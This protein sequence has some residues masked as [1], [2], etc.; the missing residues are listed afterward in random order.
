[1]SLSAARASLPGFRRLFTCLLFTGAMLPSLVSAGALSA[2][3][4]DSFGKYPG[5]SCSGGI[6]GNHDYQRHDGVECDAVGTLDIQCRSI[7]Q[8]GTGLAAHPVGSFPACNNNSFYSTYVTVSAAAAISNITLSM[9]QLCADTASGHQCWN[10]A[11]SATESVVS[12]RYVYTSSLTLTGAETNDDDDSDGVGNSTDN[13]PTI[14]NTTQTDTDSDSIGDACDSDNDNDGIADASDACPFQGDQGYGIDAN[15][16]PNLPPPADEDGDGVEDSIDNCV[17]ISNVDQLNADGDAQGDACDALP[18]NPDVLLEKTGIAKNEQLGSSIAMADMNNDGVVDLLVG[19]PMANKKAG[20]I[21]IISGKNNAALRAITGSAANQQLGAAIAVVP[22][23]NN[24]GV[25]DI[26]VGDPLADVAKLTPNGFSKLKDAGR[27]LLY[28]G[29][30]GRMLRILA[31]GDAAGDHFGVAVAAG[32]VNSDNKVDLIVGAPMNDASVKDAGQVTLFNGISNKLLYTRNGTQTGEHFGAALA[33]AN[34]HL[35][36]GSPQ[37]D[38]E[39]IK[40]AGRVSIFN[41]NDN[42]VVLPTVDGSAKGDAFG[43]A[44]AA[45]N[46]NW[47]VGIPLADSDGKKDAGSV[48][49]FSGLNT[50]PDNTLDGATAGDNFGSALNMQG[51]VNK[52]GENDIAISA[53]KFDANAAKDVGRVQVLSGVALE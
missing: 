1:M 31:E 37:F 7:H 9:R 15:G 26:A 48:Q 6:T 43:S 11:V 46:D 8:V 33:V 12:N 47:A 41:N 34:G 35:F 53:T 49:F 29:S 44:I 32:D 24:D 13:C 19:S 45:A 27:V 21:Q 10:V 3:V 39:T 22:D 20:K 17:S 50:A 28:S 40:D 25:P 36:V 52:D 38:V 42:S 51:D 18:N 14:A 4:W 5:G 16:C 23:Q 2:S 30:D